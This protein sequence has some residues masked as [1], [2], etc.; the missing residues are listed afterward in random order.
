MLN[1]LKN[2]LLNLNDIKKGKYIVNVYHRKEELWNRKNKNYSFR[3]INKSLKY[4]YF[5]GIVYGYQNT[6]R[7][8]F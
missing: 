8:R 5:G 6:R 7:K 2:I 1:M 3:K 4:F